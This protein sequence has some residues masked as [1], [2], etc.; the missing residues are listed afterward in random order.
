MTRIKIC[1][2]CRPEDAALASMAGADAIGLIFHPASPRFV[3]Q[4]LARAIIGALHPFVTPVGVFVNATLDSVDDIAVTH[5]I[6]TLQLH[7]QEPPEDCERLRRRGYHVLK[8]LKV[9]PALPSELDR[10]RG[11]VDGLVL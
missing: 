5:R 8:A 2:I 7:G 1:S 6:A 10:Y 3:D 9:T 4:E 11:C